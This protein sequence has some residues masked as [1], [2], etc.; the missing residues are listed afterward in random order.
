MAPNPNSPTPV[1]APVQP[2]LPPRLNSNQ[3]FRGQKTI[4]IDHGEQ[5]YTLRVTKEN[6]LIL[7]K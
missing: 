5:R 7:T 2:E 6:K 1:A 4:E 3:I